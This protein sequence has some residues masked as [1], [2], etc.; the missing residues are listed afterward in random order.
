M[1]NGGP[2][3]AA[4]ERV[5]P[6]VPVRAWAPGRGGEAR[7]YR[8]LD[9]V[10]GRA[11]GVEDRFVV[12]VSGAAPAR[13]GPSPPTEDRWKGREAAHGGADP[14]ATPRTALTGMTQRNV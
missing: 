12:P 10:A 9:A 4:A 3:T 13:P 1:L 7:W 14:S 6:V 11:A 2:G 8:H 5:C